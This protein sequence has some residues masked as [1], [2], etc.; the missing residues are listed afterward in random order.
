MKL[1]ALLDEYLRDQDYLRE[2]EKIKERRDEVRPEI[3]DLLEG[4]L[5]A[6]REIEEWRDKIPL[7][8]M[9]WGI[10]RAIPIIQ[11]V[12]NECQE[13]GRLGQL[14]AFIR[15]HIAIPRLTE[16][17]K[18][19]P[20]VDFVKSNYRSNQRLRLLFVLSVFW[21]IQQP[22]TYPIF[23][24]NSR[25]GVKILREKGCLTSS[26]YEIEDCYDQ[27]LDFM[28]AAS[29]IKGFLTALEIPAYHGEHFLCW[30]AKYYKK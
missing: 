1:S 30:I 21:H 16:L 2:V 12:Y 25:E 6:R 17:K 19:E 4:F 15:R 9:R 7:I 20:L 11:G 26:A 13:M 10:G 14:E 22:D 23:Y 28:I 5:A 8:N 29:E 24:P 27:Y 3:L 18:M